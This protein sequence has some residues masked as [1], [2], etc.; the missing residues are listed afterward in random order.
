MYTLLATTSQGRSY[1]RLLEWM[2]SQK[3][4]YYEAYHFDKGSSQEAIVACADN[5][6]KI[7][8]AAQCIRAV[9]DDVKIYNDKPKD[10]EWAASMLYVS[11]HHIMSTA[12]EARSWFSIEGVQEILKVSK[13]STG[14]VIYEDAENGLVNMCLSYNQENFDTVKDMGA[15]K[16]IACYNV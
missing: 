15:K 9:F 1:Q 10:R 7:I 8:A 2:D 16:I 6:E 3:I 5:K 11:L 12:K 13:V 4:Q 14:C